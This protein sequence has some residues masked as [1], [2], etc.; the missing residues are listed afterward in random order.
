MRI[1]RDRCVGM[2][3]DCKEIG[4]VGEVSELPQRCG[5]AR[6]LSLPCCHWGRECCLVFFLLGT[7]R[8]QGAWG[9]SR[10]GVRSHIQ[11]GVEEGG[12]LRLIA[13]TTKNLVIVISFV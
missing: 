9:I 4:N 10:R 2:S 13:S 5:G 3:G 7:L 1:G 6:M 11:E 12:N 8:E